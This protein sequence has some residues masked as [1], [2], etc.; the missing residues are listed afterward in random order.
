MRKIV[1]MLTSFYTNAFSASNLVKSF[2]LFRIS[3]SIIKCKFIMQNNGY[4]LKLKTRKQ[5]ESDGSFII[6][7]LFFITVYISVFNINDN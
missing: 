6:L 1:A 5:K 3:V 2:I 7:S 4:C